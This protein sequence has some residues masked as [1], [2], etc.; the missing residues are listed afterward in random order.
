MVR[1]KKK[2]IA[3]MGNELHLDFMIF[4]PHSQAS[5]QIST[6]GKWIIIEILHVFKRTLM[7]TYIFI[8]I[9][10]EIHFSEKKKKKKIREMTENVPV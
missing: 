8:K 4:H 3:E 9:S 10:S 2:L 1:R 6:T 7:F 5:K